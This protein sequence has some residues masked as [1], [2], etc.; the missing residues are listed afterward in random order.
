M[1]HK[2]PLTHAVSLGKVFNNCQS[3]SVKWVVLSEWEGEPNEIDYKQS[4]YSIIKIFP[5]LSIPHM[6][7]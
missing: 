6:M 5:S 7:T 1:T 4:W 2:R 3:S